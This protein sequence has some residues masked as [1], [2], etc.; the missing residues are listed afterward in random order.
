MTTKLGR[1]LLGLFLLLAGCLACSTDS[2]AQGA[3][4]AQGSQGTHFTAYITGYTYYTN[5][6]AK[7]AVVSHPILRKEAGGS[8]TFEDPITVAVGHS[9]AGGTHV[10]DYPAGTKFYLPYLHRY[11]IV[12]DTCGDGPTPE[13]GACH[14]GYKAPASAW[15]DIWVDGQGLGADKA[16]A[17]AMRIT[18][19]HEVI[20]NPTQNLEV[21]K[22]PICSDP[23]LDAT[24]RT[25]DAWERRMSTAQ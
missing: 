19:N 16:L 24:S 6:P 21:N 20:R 10:L 5:T 23:S 4:G 15:L 2:T 8:G 1:T 11:F 3:Q 13:K 9:K 18:G 25:S 17:C 12:E 14:T 7:S 22:D